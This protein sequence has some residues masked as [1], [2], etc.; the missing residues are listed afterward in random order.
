MREP[1]GLPW[2]SDPIPLRGR[3]I[4]PS[5]DVW[6]HRQLFDQRRVVLSGVLDDTAAN[7]VCMELMTLDA[8]GDDP[9]ELTVDSREG[10]AGAALAVM[11]VIDVLGVPV[12]GRCLGQAVG[13]S[14]GILAVC[15]HRS[16]APHARIGLV[17]PTIRMSGRAQRLEQ[18]VADAGQRW[19]QFCRRL[20]EATG[21]DLDQITADAA[22]GLFLSPDESV[23]YGI[24]DE[25]FGRS[26]TG[27]S[28]LHVD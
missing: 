25:V 22:N 13:P 15:H 27:P 6:V 21:R 1:P 3:G 10:S 24:A 28:H 8:L 16:V 17:E 18:L 5:P 2:P 20:S 26:A 4:E 23:A 19:I 9:V 7:D 12:H 11:D 14:V